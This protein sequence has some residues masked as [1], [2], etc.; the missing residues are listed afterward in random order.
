MYSEFLHHWRLDPT[1]DFLNHGSFGATPCSVLAYQAS[2]RDRMEADPVQFMMC[3]LATL[4]RESLTDLARFVDADPDD[5]VFVPN[6]THGVNAVMRS[7]SLQ[8]GEE[9]LTTSHDYYAVRNTLE[10]AAL[11]QDCRVVVAQPPL[12]ILDEQQVI[13]S[14]LSCV[15]D[16]TRMALIDHVTS[17]TA[18]I[19]PVEKI[20]RLLQDRGIDV[21]VDGAH[22]PGMFPLSLRKIN[23]AYY[24]G[25]CHKWICAPKGSGFLWVRRDKQEAIHA[26]ITSYTRSSSFSLTPFQLEF[27]WSGTVDPTAWLAVGA[28]LRFMASLVPGGWPEVMQRNRHLAIAARQIICQALP[29]E[30]PCPESMLAAMA[31][32]PLPDNDRC[33]TLLPAFYQDNLQKELLEKYHIQVPVMMWPRAPQRLLRISAQL[34]NHISQYEALAEALCHLHLH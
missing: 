22:A 23:A 15:S 12:P 1:V 9:I 33:P 26:P 32:L 25:N 18:V 24:T 8:P 7:L 34:Y 27:F 5:L 10:A 3:D 21:I 6:V 20:V 11:R 14:V 19:F 4:Y 13:D 2:L 31:A 17:P 30:I 16:R 29:C 28:A